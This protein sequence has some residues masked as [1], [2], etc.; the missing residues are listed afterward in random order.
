M[1]SRVE[2]SPP[3]GVSL[4]NVKKSN[5]LAK[6]SKRGK[7]DTREEVS[8]MWLD[9]VFEVAAGVLAIV[10]AVLAGGVHAGY[11]LVAEDSDAAK[12]AF[13]NTFEAVVE[14]AAELGKEHGK[15]IVTTVV[16]GVISTQAQ[17]QI[18]KQID[19]HSKS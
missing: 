19:K 5:K 12:K 3:L 14:G 17:S 10:P 15:A 2:I 11:K 9:D 7:S 4:V 1:S 6:T 8:F 16:V 13:E 18:N